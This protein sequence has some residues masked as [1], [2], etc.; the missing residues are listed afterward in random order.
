MATKHH[1][2]RG[3]LVARQR[4]TAALTTLSAQ[5]G[6]EPVDLDRIHN[7]RF[8]QFE[9]MQRWEA[10]ADWAEQ[11]AA[12]L[13]ESPDESID[14]SAAQMAVSADP[15]FDEDAVAASEPVDYTTWTVADLRAE[16]DARGIDVPAKAKK[17][18]LLALLSGEEA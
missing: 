17:A 9:A 11:I 10:L 1:I 12:G 8:P 18:E 15:I 5:A 14:E 4:L 2:Q 6:V 7:R 16:L 3:T 13:A